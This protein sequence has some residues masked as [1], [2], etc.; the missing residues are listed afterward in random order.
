LPRARGKHNIILGEPNTTVLLLGNEAIARGAIEY[1]IGFAAAYPGTPSSEVVE[2]LS[3]VA[4]E[5]GIYVEWSVNEKVAFESAYAAAMSGVPSLTAMKHVGL[6]VAA[7]PLMTSAYTGV[8]AGFIIVT[9]D[10]PYM[11]S[12]QNEQD[13]RWY[14]LHAYIPVLE[15]CDP[16]EAKDLTYIGLELSE[17]LHH[18]FILRSVTRVS[19]VRAPVKLGIM[20]G[21][22]AIGSFPRNPGR[23]TVIPENARKMK[24]R[25]LEKWRVIESNLSELPYNRIEGDG[26]VLIV[27]SGIGYAYTSEAVE[28]LGVEAKVLKIASPVPLPKKLVEKAVEGVEKV[29]IIE[30]CDPVVEL[31]LKALLKDMD[32]RVEVY[33]ENLLGRR[34]E[35]TLD[36]VL[37]SMAKVFKV[38]WSIPELI[39]PPIEPPP[40]PPILCPGCPHRATFYVLK[41]ASKRLKVDPIYSGDIGCYSL[42]IQPPFN[43]QDV[44]IEMGGSIGLANGFAH[45]VKERPVVAIIGDSTFFHAGLPPLVNAIYNRAP[46]LI[47]VLDNETTAM[48]GFQPHPGT[49][50]KADGSPGKRVCIEC[51]AKVMGADYVDVFDPYNVRTALEAVEKGFKVVMAGGVAVLVARRECS[52]NAARSGRLSGVYQVDTLKCIKCMLCL[53]ELACPAIKVEKGFPKVVENLCVGCGVCN[54]ICPVKA[55]S[56]IR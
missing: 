29:L 22:R 21:S 39:K 34:G 32:L 5:L 12:S 52:L 38:P 15:P 36:R 50:V 45:T 28:T 51:I 43:A 13:N 37:E 4:N 30:E 56:K 18:P 53:N 48:T 24:L 41:M 16:Q 47:I 9:A 20:R 40:R 23:W 54:E 17:K 49:G 1:G 19:H 6:N 14:G 2:T 31:Q 55:F 35:L 25:L 8:E 7:D 42:G 46:M 26:K 27:A 44:I 10:D 3:S 33:G 11:H